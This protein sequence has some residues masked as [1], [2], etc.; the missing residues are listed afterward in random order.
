MADGTSA[1]GGD[2]FAG[3]SQRVR[4]NKACS[5]EPGTLELEKEFRE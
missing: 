3:E 1:L 2:T 4:S 5:S